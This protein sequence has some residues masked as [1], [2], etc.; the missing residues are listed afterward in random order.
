MF[1]FASRHSDF[2]KRAKITINITCPS[3]REN[4]LIASI[5]PK[6][7]CGS[8]QSFS[9]NL[10]HFYL[11]TQICRASARPAC[12]KLRSVIQDGKRLTS[13]YKRGLHAMKEWARKG[14]TH[15]TLVPASRAL[16]PKHDSFMTPQETAPF[17]VFSEKGRAGTGRA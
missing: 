5:Y 17:D 10:A 6:E 2:A 3:T 13:T 16:L 15:F 9:R 12:K 8:R 14:A 7:G 11:P 4:R 1:L